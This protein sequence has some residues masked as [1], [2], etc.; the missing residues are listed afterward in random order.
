MENI[1][2]KLE[3]E[4]IRIYE[5]LKK[6][7]IEQ[8]E[9]SND[10]KK[11]ISD[12]GFLFSVN[13]WNDFSLSPS[14]MNYTGNLKRSLE[15]YFKLFHLHLIDPKEI[16][17]EKIAI[18]QSAIILIVNSFEVYF[19]D[20]FKMLSSHFMTGYLDFDD[21]IRFI[22]K[23]KLERDFIRVFG[24]KAHFNFFLDEL[25]INRFDFQQ[26]ERLK[27]AFNLFEIDLTENIQLWGKIFDRGY[28]EKRH[29]YTHGDSCRKIE[30]YI[31]FKDNLELLSSMILDISQFIYE[32]ELNRL[33]KY[34]D[35]TEMN[36]HP[37]NYDLR[38]PDFHPLYLH[39]SNIVGG[40][41]WEENDYILTVKKNV[42]TKEKEY[43]CW[44]KISQ[45]SFEK[46]KEE[47]DYQ[48]PK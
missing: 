48:P 28:M 31:P 30:E 2:E 8:I 33:K 41:N 42:N 26:G 9:I 47:T 25:K 10:S 34:P 15:M 12:T 44:K 11:G 3:N 17:F 20:N 24:H 19:I 5:K 18:F 6:L 32:F 16:T 22:K 36:L 35:P 43:E 23:N 46:L 7:N 40:C 1:D 21:L 14:F 45:E 37:E 4:K 27:S 29:K 13:G 38:N 39:E